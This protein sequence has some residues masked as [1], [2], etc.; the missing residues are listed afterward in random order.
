MN[1]HL[2]GFQ[3]F[4]FKIFASFH[5]GQINHLQY[6]GDL[7]HFNL[8]P[9]TSNQSHLLVF[10]MQS[11]RETKINAIPL[12]RKKHEDIWMHTQGS[13]FPGVQGHM[14]LDF[15]VGP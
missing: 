4:F 14:P 9:Y 11:P 5:V 7:L 15:A 13:T 2:Q 12:T 3:S 6:Q 8:A 1:T 10:L